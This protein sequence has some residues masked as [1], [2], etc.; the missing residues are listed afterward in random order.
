M[1]E[2][3]VLSQ[4][5][6][7]PLHGYLIAQIANDMIGPW[8]KISNGTLYPLLNRL[9]RSGLIERAGDAPS[10]GNGQGEQ[11][12]R[13][14]RITEA[15]RKRFHQVMLDTSSN[16]GDY[17]RIFH[18]KVPYLDLLPVRERLHLLNH[19][20]NYCQAC[21][22]HMQTQAANLLHEIEDEQATFRDLA[23][24]SMRHREQLWQTEIE[25]ITQLRAQVAE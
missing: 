17:Q 21:V 6:R 9:E 5:M 19:Y 10:P 25:W 3:I 24:N 22:L 18:L 23:L 8:A 15:G 2:L 7:F 4:L 16:I 11:Q 1:Y 14:F 13:T 20:L 12:A